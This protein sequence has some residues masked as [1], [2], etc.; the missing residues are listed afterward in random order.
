MKCESE[1][2][3]FIHFILSMRQIECM[4]FDNG[5][6]YSQKFTFYFVNYI[7][8]LK[9]CVGKY[10]ISMYVMRRDIRNKFIFGFDLFILTFFSVTLMNSIRNLIPR[11][12]FESNLIF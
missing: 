1:N 7:F 5:Q 6:G 3:T 9:R 8:L 4:Y 12:K 10:N 11:S 2:Y